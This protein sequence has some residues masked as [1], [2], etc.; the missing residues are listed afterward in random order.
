MAS[1]YVLLQVGKMDDSRAGSP[2][3]TLVG[4]KVLSFLV[5]AAIAEP[6]KLSRGNLAGS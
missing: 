5:F 3:G 2:V 6:L 1:H 4:G